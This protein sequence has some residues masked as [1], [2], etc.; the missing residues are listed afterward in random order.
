MVDTETVN[1]FREAEEMAI[2]ASTGFDGPNLV[3][4]DLK[5]MAII[6][7]ANTTRVAKLLGV[8]PKNGWLKRLEGKQIHRSQL[9]AI[10]RLAI[11]SQTK[12]LRRSSIS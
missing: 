11:K 8:K 3:V 1:R 5:V 6:R 2:E 7:K 10:V 4:V 12:L 9:N